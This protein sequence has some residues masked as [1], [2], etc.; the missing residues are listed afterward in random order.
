M[1]T[2]EQAVIIGTGL[3][4][5]SVGLALRRAGVRVWLRDR[6]SR[7]VA[8]AVR[9][10]AGHPLPAT[11]RPSVDL[12]V[13]AVP[14]A[15]VGEVLRDAQREGL[16]KHYTDVASVKAPIIVAAAG[17]GCDMRSFVPGHPMAGSEQSGPGAARADLFVGRTW[18]LCPTAAVRPEAV[19]TARALAE[20]TGA[21]PT[22]LSAEAHDRAAAI[23]SHLPHLVSSALAAQLRTADSTALRLAGA[24]LRDVT[25]IAGGNVPLWLDILSQN[26]DPVADTV[27]D[28]IEDLRHV[29]AELRSRAA[30]ADSN[31]SPAPALA[32]LLDRGNDGR[33][34]LMAERSS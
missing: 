22:E 6:D 31:A 20:L 17:H 13:L 16:A 15:A 27:D 5:T 3:V 12:A 7:A 14:P 11:A 26:A 25:R 8:E 30:I 29:A 28:L 21:A 32:S 2:V 9:L 10:G 33:Q 18:A 34:R 1:N 23:I 24:G 19:A 4:G